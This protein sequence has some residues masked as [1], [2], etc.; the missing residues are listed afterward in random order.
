M[1]WGTCLPEGFLHRVHIP[2]QFEIHEDESLGARKILGYDRAGIRCFYF[3]EFVLTE[4]RFDEDECIFEALSYR[5]VIFGWKTLEEQWL[6]LKASAEYA[7]GRK[8][9]ISIKL[10]QQVYE[11]DLDR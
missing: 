6:K 9:R 2:V 8:R 11:R 5:E 3:H 7:W 4:E 10:I 1:F